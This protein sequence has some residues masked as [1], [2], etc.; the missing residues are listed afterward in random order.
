MVRPI[1]VQQVILQASAIEKVQQVQQKQF[2][3]QQEY[4]GIQLKEEKSLA[5]E[6]IQDAS[7]TEK[8]EI[9]E[10]ENDKK[11]QSTKH[12]MRRSEKPDGERREVEE[13]SGANAMGRFIDI[14]I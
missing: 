3:V 12:G 10:R 8:S 4:I 9:R 11:R 7:E 6:K 1:D 14:K 5:E 2:G 13:N